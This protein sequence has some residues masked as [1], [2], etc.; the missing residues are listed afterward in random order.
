MKIKVR[1]GLEI[2]DECPPF[3]IAE[4]GS[5]WST[6]EECLVSIEKSKECGAD[7]VKFQLFDLESL[8]GP[9]V[10][11]WSYTLSQDLPSVK[12][13]SLPVD[14]LPKL[15][16]HSDKV[17]IELMCSAFSPE[18]IDAVNPYVN[19]HKLA[20]AEMCH[21][22]MLEKLKRLRKPVIMSTGA[23]SLKEIQTA[24]SLL[25][26]D[27]PSCVLMYCVSAYPA[28]NINLGAIVLFQS[29]HPLVGYSDHSIDI[30]YIP[31]AAVERGACIIEKH[32]N[33]IGSTGPDAPHSLDEIEFRQMVQSIRAKPIFPFGP[34]REEQPM[35]DRHNRR[36]IVT[37]EIK[38]GEKFIEGENFGI[39][40]SLL[41]Q[42]RNLSPFEIN[43][44]I[45]KASKSNLQAGE[46]ISSEM[47]G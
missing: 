3:I 24:L 30:N 31:K 29:L 2:G 11:T 28:K 21:V 1:D 38:K 44:V 20:S 33:F 34:V 39:Y 9:R 37:K 35:I 17:G 42:P 43:A 12:S 16:E 7:A 40:R 41:D 6:L 18:L 4:V 10:Q 8:Y 23:H 5:N 22:R 27:K 25:S 32:C 26:K 14:W 47:I 36:L 46:A 13:A 19:I 45:G 15:K